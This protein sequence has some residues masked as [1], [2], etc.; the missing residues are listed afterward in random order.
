MAKSSTFSKMAE[1]KGI[2][3]KAFYSVHEI[4]IVTGWS[5]STI[6]RACRDGYLKWI[7]PAGIRQGKRIASEWVDDWLG[8][9]HA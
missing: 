1:R 3:A 6:N 4:S 8:A 9:A 2:G 7:M 5:E